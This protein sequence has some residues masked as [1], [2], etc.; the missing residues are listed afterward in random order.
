MLTP[1]PRQ[2]ALKRC[3]VDGLDE[4]AVEAH[5]LGSAQ[6]LGLPVPRQCDESDI[7]KTRKRAQLACDLIAIQFGKTNIQ[8]HD[9]GPE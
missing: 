2:R 7:A 5:L 1:V 4:V 8:Q 3:K 9:I 6:V